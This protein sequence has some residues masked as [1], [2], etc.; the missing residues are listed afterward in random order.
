MASLRCLSIAKIISDVLVL[1]VDTLS[2][3][4]TTNST[5]VLQMTWIHSCVAIDSTLNHLTVVVN[6]KKL[7]DKAFPIPEGAQPPSNLTERLLVLKFYSGIWYQS[8]SKVSN[9]NNFSKRM[10][11]SEMVSRSQYL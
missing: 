10:T 2:Y 7:E 11:L 9:L 8:N 4:G 5:P 6:G 1:Q 3:I